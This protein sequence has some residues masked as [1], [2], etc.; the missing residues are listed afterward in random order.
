VGHFSQP[1]NNLGSATFSRFLRRAPA[2]TSVAEGMSHGAGRLGAD[3]L[4]NQPF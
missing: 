3:T 2:I 1:K 4:P